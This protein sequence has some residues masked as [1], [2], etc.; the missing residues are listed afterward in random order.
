MVQRC[1]ASKNCFIDPVQRCGMS[2]Q[3]V[4]GHGAALHRPKK[5][6]NGGSATLQRVN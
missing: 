2:V 1:G 5:Q 6:G 3:Q 4:N